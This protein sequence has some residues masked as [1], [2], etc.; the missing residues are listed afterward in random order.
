MNNEDQS[1][2]EVGP[3]VGFRDDALTVGDLSQ[4]FDNPMYAEPG[5]PVS[6]VFLAVVRSAQTSFYK[7][8]L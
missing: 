2:V 3:S 1:S 8:G 7:C 5:G 4:G 6:R